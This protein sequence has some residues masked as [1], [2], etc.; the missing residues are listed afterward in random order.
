MHPVP[1]WLLN[2]IELLPF[3]FAL[4][5]AI[6]FS[7]PVERVEIRVSALILFLTA[8]AF[9]H[10]QQFRQWFSQPRER[11]PQRLRIY[12]GL[13][14]VLTVVGIY[15][16]RL[17]DIP[18]TFIGD[19]I[20]D[21][22]QDARYLLESPEEFL[23]PG[24]YD[25]YSRLLAVLYSPVEWAFPR[26]IAA[27]RLFTSMIALLSVY[28][29]YRIVRQ[30]Y[31]FT[32]ALSASVCFATTPLVL[33][34]ARENS[35]VSWNLFIAVTCLCWF[36]AST[37]TPTRREA[38]RL[39][40]L[41]GWGCYFHLAAVS[42]VLVTITCW[43]AYRLSRSDTRQGFART[44]LPFAL[45]LILALGAGSAYFFGL[46]EAAVERVDPDVPSEGVAWY[47]LEKYL[48]TISRLFAPLPQAMYIPPM[49][50][51]L[52]AFPAVAFIGVAVALLR[53]RDILVRPTIALCGVAFLALAFLNSAITDYPN[54]GHRIVV[55]IPFLMYLVAAGVAWV[56][57]AITAVTV[58]KRWTAVVSGSLLFF[59][60]G[61]FF[62][63][64]F[65]YW[66]SM[67]K[68]ELRNTDECSY[69]VSLAAREL[70]SFAFAEWPACINVPNKRLY[71]CFTLAHSEQA[72]SYFSGGH[73]I[74]PQI[75][76]GLPK[77]HLEVSLCGVGEA[78]LPAQTI[79][80]RNGWNL[81]VD[82]SVLKEA[83][84]GTL[85]FLRAH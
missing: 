53:G 9:I 18:R 5:A 17:E 57:G 21:G 36:V 73:E 47:I 11:E 69:L 13:L 24:S 22:P 38:A 2:F 60:L 37:R 7:V 39:G 52:V 78:T 61:T 28:L 72:L 66:T 50:V 58:P 40:F 82:A 25:G 20:R 83:K 34:L 32:A 45:G 67:Q 15:L 19:V 41:C 8:A 26:S 75:A 81:T 55:V 77:H 48:Y 10:I 51:N 65:F 62:S 3:G 35:V 27:T 46:L 16:Y 63:S 42:T 59:L 4:L 12:T 76:A 44:V 79:P 23:A 54:S 14:V 29:F 31:S 49:K 71:R 30:H 43:A 85:P 64:A 1:R 6:L 80:L 70:R 74:V 33:Y 68:Q 84:K 56:E